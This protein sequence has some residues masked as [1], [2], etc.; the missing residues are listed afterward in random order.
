MKKALIA[1]CFIFIFLSQGCRSTTCK[2]YGHPNN[3]SHELVY[4]YT[5][6]AIANGDVSYMCVLVITNHKHGEF[7][8]MELANMAK[9]YVETTKTKAPIASVDFAFQKHNGCLPDPH[10]N[11]G[12]AQNCV[13]V[14][15]GFNKKSQF[16]QNTSFNFVGLYN[17]R[18][19]IMYPK[20]QFDI[21]SLLK[22]KD[23][24]F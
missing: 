9:N 4:Y 14:S 19:F 20:Y 23:I 15:F 10:I 7:T 1:S 17:D 3:K 2:S 5:D 24:V 21:D 6:T 8:L 22:S 13:K 12:K 11:Y 16:S 18:E